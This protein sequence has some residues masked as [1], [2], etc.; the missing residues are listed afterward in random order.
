MWVLILS[1]VLSAPPNATSAAPPCLILATKVSSKIGELKARFFK[2]RIHLQVLKTPRERMVD[3]R[4]FLR[5]K[6]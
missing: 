1:I 4:E 6:E 5:A 2:R 3:V